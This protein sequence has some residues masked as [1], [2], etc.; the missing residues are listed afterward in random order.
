MAKFAHGHERELSIYILK[1]EINPR[2]PGAFLL[3]DGI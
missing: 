1:F 3:T 2:S